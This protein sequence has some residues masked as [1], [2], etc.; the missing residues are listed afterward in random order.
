MKNNIT[1]L[2]IFLTSIMSFGQNKFEPGVIVLKNGQEK[3][4]LIQFI[5]KV[6]ENKIWYKTSENDELVSFTSNQ[7]NFYTFDKINKKV[8]SQTLNLRTVFMEVLIEGKADLLFYRDENKNNHFFLKSKKSDLK[9]LKVQKRISNN[10]NF[11]FKEF[12]GILNLEFNDCNDISKEINSTKFSLKGLAKTFKAYNNCVNELGFVSERIGRKAIQSIN[13]SVGYNFASIKESAPNLRGRDFASSSNP[14][15]GLEYSYN[16]NFFNSHL[17]FNIGLN[18]NEI[19]TDGEYVRSN[20]FSRNFE[21]TRVNL[22]LLNIKLGAQYFLFE[23]RKKINPVLGVYYINSRILNKDDAYLRINEDGDQEFLY[24]DGPTN[25]VGSTSGFGLEIGAD[26][27]ISTK[28]SI[29]F[30]AGYENIGDFLENIDSNYPIQSYFF[31]LGYS[32][33]LNK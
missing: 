1:I 31:K 26:F 10:K 5:R 18:Y 16:P 13:I 32:L 21:T 20:I 4:G 15:L 25:I 7:V 2:I 3:K 33:N 23:T 17:S 19:N 14:V 29:Q 11:I 6:N 24:S 9:E 22:K 12:I 8:T 27:L 30:R 28:S